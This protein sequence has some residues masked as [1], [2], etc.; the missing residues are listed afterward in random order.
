MAKGALGSALGMFVCLVSR[1]LATG[2]WLSFE[3]REWG[4]L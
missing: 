3:F 1:L 2:L 4:A